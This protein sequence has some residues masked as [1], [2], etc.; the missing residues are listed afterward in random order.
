MRCY[1]LIGFQITFAGT[2]FLRQQL[3]NIHR[4]GGGMES[5]RKKTEYMQKKIK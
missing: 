2:Q 1:Q 3:I 5:I 4:K